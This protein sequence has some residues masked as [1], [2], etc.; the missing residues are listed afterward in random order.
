M[1]Y[2]PAWLLLAKTHLEV[3]TTNCRPLLLLC[4][5]VQ[6]ASVGAAVWAVVTVLVE[7]CHAHT[8]HCP[9]TRW[10]G[11][12]F[13]GLF[14]TAKNKRLWAGCL[15]SSLWI[16]VSPCWGYMLTG[17][18]TLP[19]AQCTAGVCGSHRS[20]LCRLLLSLSAEDGL[21][22]LQ[23]Q[24]SR[25]MIMSM[26]LMDIPFVCVL[27][28]LRFFNYT[29]PFSM[30]TVSPFQDV[31]HNQC[32]HLGS[33]TPTFRIVCPSD[34]TRAVRGAAP[35]RDRSG[36]GSAPDRQGALCAGALPARRC[37]AGPAGIQLLPRCSV[38]EAVSLARFRMLPFSEA[39]GYIR[40]L[41]RGSC[42]LGRR[43][44]RSRTARLLLL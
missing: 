2:V 11:C 35:H 20:F 22:E 15:I 23:E 16:P 33:L 30:S 32:L 37:A 21:L 29:K 26:S 19:S 4:G 34:L 40:W 28:S 1:N 39:L 8:Q 38:H 36:P 10:G 9:S 6:L 31:G 17:W 24:R 25:S 27:K 12:R 13:P 44:S 7:G 3:L 42:G 41:L 14:S 5:W 18:V 43:C